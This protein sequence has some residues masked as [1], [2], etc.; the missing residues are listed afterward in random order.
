MQTGDPE[1]QRVEDLRRCR[2]L[3][4]GQVKSQDRER[5]DHLN[6]SVYSI[7]L[8]PRKTTPRII[9][10]DD[11]HDLRPGGFSPV[12]AERTANAIVNELKD[13]NSRVE[14]GRA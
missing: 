11:P 7:T 3:A 12:C 8:T 14:G 5:C 2:V 6:F 10:G 4:G 9:V 1:I 13:Q